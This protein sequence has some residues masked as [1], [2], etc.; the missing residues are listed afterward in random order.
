M[1]SR[2]NIHMKN[3]IKLTIMRIRERKKRSLTKV[4]SN[5]IC[6]NF[7]NHVYKFKYL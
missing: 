7:Y 5:N 3:T 2:K 1:R 6:M 4:I